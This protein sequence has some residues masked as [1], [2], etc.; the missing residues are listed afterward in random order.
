LLQQT[1]FKALRL[2]YLFALSILTSILDKRSL[3]FFVL[4]GLEDSEFNISIAR[5]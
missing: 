5:I 4:E 1:F 3:L 2:G